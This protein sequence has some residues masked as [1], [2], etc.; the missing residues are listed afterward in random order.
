VVVVL[1]FHSERVDSREHVHLQA[2]GV[3][4]EACM[5]AM[6]RTSLLS[7]LFFDFLLP[8]QLHHPHL[9]D[10]LRRFLQV[11]PLV[12]EIRIN[13]KT[14][15]GMLLLWMVWIMGVGKK[16]WGVEHLAESLR[17]ECL[18]GKEILI[19]DNERNNRW[20]RKRRSSPGLDDMRGSKRR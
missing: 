13:T 19:L 18:V 17:K 8:L 6:V 3:A 2:G 10:L 14:E 4:G 7:D 15:M 9:C 1:Q 16:V 12:Q 20:N 11:C 5:E